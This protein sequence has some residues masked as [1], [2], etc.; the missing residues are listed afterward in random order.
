MLLSKELPLC[1]AVS[2]RQPREMIN[3]MTVLVHESRQH[4]IPLSVGADTAVPVSNRYLAHMQQVSSVAGVLQS[5]KACKHN[6]SHILTDDNASRNVFGREE[7]QA[8]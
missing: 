3:G 4:V 5:Q 2:R 1:W 7:T 6:L 8:P